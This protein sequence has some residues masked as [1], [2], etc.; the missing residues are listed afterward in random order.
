M[1]HIAAS[2][3]FKAARSFF[4]VAPAATELLIG[5]T[6]RLPKYATASLSFYA[7]GSSTTAGSSGSSSVTTK[8]Q[9]RPFWGSTPQAKVNDMKPFGI[10]T[11]GPTMVSTIDHTVASAA[12]TAGIPLE[13]VKKAEKP[14]AEKKPKKKKEA[15][16]ENKGEKDAA[17]PKAKVTKT[18]SMPVLEKDYVG[19]DYMSKVIAF[20][21]DISAT[22][23]RKIVDDVFDIVIQVRIF[24][25]CGNFTL[26]TNDTLRF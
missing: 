23:A 2:L 4:A 8:S 24:F 17:V 1:Y 5:T 20:K 11:T 13:D 15:T 3:R 16:A 12:A 7:T 26:C 19:V 18:K 6:T 9:Q 21:N 10:T 14:K 22:K 25:R